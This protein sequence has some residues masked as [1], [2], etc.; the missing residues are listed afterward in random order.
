MKIIEHGRAGRDWVDDIQGHTLGRVAWA[1]RT[2]QDH[3]RRSK[4]RRRAGDR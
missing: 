3:G 2:R 4:V 1:W